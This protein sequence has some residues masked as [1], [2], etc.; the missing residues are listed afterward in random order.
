MLILFTLLTKSQSPKIDKSKI[1]G[2]WAQISHQVIHKDSILEHKF[3]TNGKTYTFNQDGTFMLKYYG[4]ASD[5][6]LIGNWKL[7]KD[8]RKIIL[9]DNEMNYATLPSVSIKNQTLNIIKFTTSS[10]VVKELL[11]NDIRPGLSTYM[12]Q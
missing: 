7:S 9:F 4:E 1:I 8:L 2:T 5:Y 11:P 3:Q 6:A 10:F 12:K